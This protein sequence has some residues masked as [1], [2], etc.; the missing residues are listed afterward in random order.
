MVQGDKAPAHASPYQ[1]QVFKEFGI[2]RFRR[3]GNPPD[4]NGITSEEKPLVE[5]LLSTEYLWS[6]GGGSNG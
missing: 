4:L 2:E 5:V 6:M 1:E 3:P